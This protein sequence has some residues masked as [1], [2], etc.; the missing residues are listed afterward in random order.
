MICSPTGLAHHHHHHCAVAVACCVMQIQIQIQISS[1]PPFQVC[2]RNWF[3][4]LLL[5]LLLLPPLRPLV[6]PF[7][8]V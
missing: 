1:V 6:L 4:P 2:V 8:R 5:L 7:M 3:L